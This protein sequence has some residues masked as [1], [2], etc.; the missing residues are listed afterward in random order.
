MK[1]R[2][3]EKKVK[4]LEAR[5]AALE[6]DCDPDVW[7]CPLCGSEAAPGW[8]GRMYCR[9][10]FG[11]CGYFIV[12]SARKKGRAVA[13]AS[14][15]FFKTSITRSGKTEPH[16]DDQGPSEAHKYELYLQ[17]VPGYDPVVVYRD[18]EFVCQLIE[19]AGLP[20]LKTCKDGVEDA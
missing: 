9:Q 18:G 1:R 12:R 11:V 5:I 15:R 2:E 10:D 20:V 3:L 13:E 16:P 19:G 4:H 17:F 14:S 6:D 8:Y 7:R